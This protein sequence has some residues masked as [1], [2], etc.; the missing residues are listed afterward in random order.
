I[1]SSP[2]PKEPDKS[3]SP[4]QDHQCGEGPSP[5][6]CQSDRLF[7]GLH[8]DRSGRRTFRQ[9][10]QNRFFLWCLHLSCLL[11]SG[12]LP[13]P[14]PMEVVKSSVPRQRLYTRGP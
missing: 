14:W 3:P 1:V 13:C 5:F 10:T 11:L 7:V 2:A 9:A 6:S 12:L 8:H 4:Y